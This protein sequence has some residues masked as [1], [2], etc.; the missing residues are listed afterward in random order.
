VSKFWGGIFDVD[1][2]T[3]QLQELKKASLDPDFW[4]KPEKAQTELKKIAQL[5]K[6]IQDFAR[7]RL[8]C[9]DIEILLEFYTQNEL[10][11]EEVEAQI[12][13]TETLISE[14]ELQKSL[15]QPED[16]LGCLLKITAGSGGTESCDWAEMLSRMYTMWAE[17][18][19]HPIQEVYRQNGEQVGIKTVTLQI[20]APFTYGW[21]KGENGVHRLIR[22]S[23]FNA[24]NKRQT[25]FAAVFAQPLVDDSIQ[26]DLNLA[27]IDWDTFR[28]SGAGGQHVN[29]TESA[30]RLTHRPTGIVIECQ[31][32][33]SQ[34]QN[35][36]TAIQLL[37]SELY[38][39]EIAQRNQVKAQIEASKTEI[40]WGNH[41]RSYVLDD[42]RIK[43]HRSQHETS[44]I[45]KVLDGDIDDFLK[46]TL[47]THTS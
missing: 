30:V 20:D 46:A 2:Q 26:I 9:D 45:K 27:D 1:N 44:N 41:I 4:H 10:S 28:A 24:K 5:E 42:R 22:P 15:S 12:A 37:K 23:P 21:L 34:H 33:R 3:I 40:E 19:N 14:V 11:A 29:R 8:A 13:N 43:D 35:R 36:E 17:A 39:L 6:V 38:Q 47:L 32:E 16:A 18:H 25:T 7:L 31:Q